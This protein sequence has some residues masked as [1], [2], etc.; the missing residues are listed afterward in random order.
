MRQALV[1]HAISTSACRFIAEYSLFRPGQ[2]GMVI[3][4]SYKPSKAGD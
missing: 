1:N 4:F 2:G 3:A